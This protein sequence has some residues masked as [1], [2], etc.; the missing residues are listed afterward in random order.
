MK[1]IHKKATTLLID[2]NIFHPTKVALLSN[3]TEILS[4][5]TSTNTNKIHSDI[6]YNLICFIALILFKLFYFI[7]PPHLLTLRYLIKRFQRELTTI[8]SIIIYHIKVFS[9]F[10]SKPRLLYTFFLQHLFNP[11]QIF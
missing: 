6:I 4:V 7:N 8:T 5:A 2:S 1:S 10:F 3:E 11:I 9:K